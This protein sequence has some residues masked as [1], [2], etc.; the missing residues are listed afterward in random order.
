MAW[1]REIFWISAVNNFRVTSSYIKTTD[2]TTADTLSRS[3]NHLSAAHFLSLLHSGS[4]KNNPNC[5]N[6]SLPS[7]STLPMQ[8][9]IAL[10]SRP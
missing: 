7:L 2:N 4:L 8:D 1:P 9:Q 5:I 6:L 3:H 10:K